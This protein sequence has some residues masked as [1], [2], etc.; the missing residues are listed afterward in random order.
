MT[1]KNYNT[2]DC[3]VLDIVAKC[4]ILCGSLMETD[5]NNTEDYQGNFN[6]RESSDLWSD[7]VADF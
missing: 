5:I 7:D 3:L 2:P 1:K 4:P 6:T